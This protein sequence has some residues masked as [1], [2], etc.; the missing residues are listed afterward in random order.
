MSRRSTTRAGI[1]PNPTTADEALDVLVTAIRRAGLGNRP[2]CT[3]DGRWCEAQ[4]RTRL[5]AAHESAERA[6][7]AAIDAHA[8]TEEQLRSRAAQV[9]ADRQV[10][11]VL[12]GGVASE[13]PSARGLSDFKERHA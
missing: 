4:L 10:A 5:E 11:R 8:L 1:A 12:R 3:S 13:T 9:R 7:A 2:S 6:L